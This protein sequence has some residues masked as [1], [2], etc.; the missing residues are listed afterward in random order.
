[1]LARHDGALRFPCSEIE[2]GQ[3]VLCGGNQGRG[4]NARP[5][6]FASGFIECWKVFD[7]ISAE[8]AAEAEVR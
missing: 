7:E 5:G 8:R 4:S 1:M 3:W 6:D 2:A